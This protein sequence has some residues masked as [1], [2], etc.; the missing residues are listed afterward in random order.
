MTTE[1]TL[2]DDLA[3]DAATARAAGATR[4]SALENDGKLISQNRSKEAVSAFELVCKKAIVAAAE[5][6]ADVAALKVRQ[7]FESQVLDG[8]LR[9]GGLKFTVVY[10]GI[11]SSAASVN[12][13]GG[14][15]LEFLVTIPDGH[16]L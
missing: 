5:A 14:A 12:H 9:R 16:G 2:T 13:V 3:A 15:T 11:V 1:T 8:M 4:V 6:G 10:H 7:G